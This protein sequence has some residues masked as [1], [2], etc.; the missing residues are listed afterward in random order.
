MEEF[1]IYCC[2]LT[3]VLEIG[4]GSAWFSLAPPPTLSTCQ[5]RRQRY[6]FSSH[7][8]CS[9]WGTHSHSKLLQRHPGNLKVEL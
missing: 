9:L 5:V 4:E 2:A 1:I 7:V 3:L 6:S 8:L